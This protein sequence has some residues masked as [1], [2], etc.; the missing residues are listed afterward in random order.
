MKQD[1]EIIN[2]ELCLKDLQTIERVYEDLKGRMKRKKE[3]K[4]EEELEIIEKVE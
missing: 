3:K 4:D 1:I 2:N